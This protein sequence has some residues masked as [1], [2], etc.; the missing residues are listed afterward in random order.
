[1]TDDDFLERGLFTAYNIGISE[2]QDSC[3]RRCMKNQLEK[4]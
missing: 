1:M 4:R 3:L 2:M